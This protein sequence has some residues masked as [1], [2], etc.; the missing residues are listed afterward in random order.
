MRHPDV[1]CALADHSGDSNFELCYFPDFPGALDAFRDAG[2]PAAWLDRYW[3]DANRRRQKHFKPLNIVGM[4]AH[5]SPDPQAPA[6][7][8][9]IDWPFDLDTGEFRP[10]VWDRWRAWDPIQMLDRHADNLRRMRAIYLDCGSRD[11][12]ALHWGTR[13][14]AAR[15]AGHGIGVRHEEFDDGHMNITYRY[16]VSLPFLA[17]TILAA[18]G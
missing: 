4:A 18:G 1:F 13:T 5:Y 15:L 9:R 10:A 3:A 6:A 7:D 12:Y 17:E 14:L 11:E 2:G 16:D 8:L